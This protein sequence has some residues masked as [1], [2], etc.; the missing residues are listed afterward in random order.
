[1]VGEYRVVVK[2]KRVEYNLS[3]KRKY[4][5]IQGDSGTG[6][7]KLANLLRLA[8]SSKHIKVICDIPVRVILQKSSLEKYLESNEKAIYI[9]DEDVCTEFKTDNKGIPF[10]KMTVE[11]EGYF[12]LMT[13]RKFGVLPYSVYEIYD[14]VRNINK[15]SIYSYTMKNTFYWRNSSPVN[16][17]YFITEDK[18]VGFLFFQDTL[19]CNVVSADGN[20]NI[21]RE[22]LKA[23]NSGSKVIF[24][25]ADGAAFGCGIKSYFDEVNILFS[26][27]NIRLFIPE[28]FEYLVLKS[29]IFKNFDSDLLLNTCRYADSKQYFSWERFYTHLLGDASSNFGGYN[30]DGDDVPKY[31]SDN[32]D[33]IYKVMGEIANA[34]YMVGV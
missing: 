28:S 23:V 24:V 8:D 14:L 19:N 17:D 30:K 34:K 2:T 20:G 3:F 10:A 1:M 27:I 4:T 6:K 18:K 21:R 33:K 13:R 26:S 32:K 16:S 25:F 29:G 31:I 5:F 11:A 12:V 7:T 9:I 15:S 22:I